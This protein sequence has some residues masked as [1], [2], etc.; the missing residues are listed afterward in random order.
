MACNE[1]VLA[2]MSRVNPDTLVDSTTSLLLV[3]AELWHYAL[4][5]VSIH[6]IYTKLTILSCICTILQLYIHV[7]TFLSSINSVSLSLPPPS[8]SFTH[9]L[10]HS[11]L[12]V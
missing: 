12:L 7:V 3:R 10:T 6:H 1:A 11:H 4:E 8:L 2:L 5:K 9:S